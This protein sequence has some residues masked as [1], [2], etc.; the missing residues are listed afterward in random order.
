MSRRPVGSGRQATQSARPRRPQP[1]QPMGKSA[2]SARVTNIPS[3]RDGA[4]R[5]LGREARAWKRHRDRSTAD[6]QPRECRGR[7]DAC[8]RRLR[9]RT[10]EAGTTV[11]AEG[12]FGYS[13]CAYGRVRLIATRPTGRRGRC[14]RAICRGDDRT[15]RLERTRRGTR[16]ARRIADGHRYDSR[17]RYRGTYDARITGAACD[18]S[19]RDAKVR[20]LRHPCGCSNA[21]R[22]VVRFMRGDRFGATRK[23]GR[24]YGRRDERSDRDRPCE[25]EITGD[26]QG[27]AGRTGACD[28]QAI[29]QTRRKRVARRLLGHAQ[30]STRNRSIRTAGRVATR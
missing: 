3:Y 28:A 5:P 9:L 26:E 1:T 4:G 22:D 16:S 27:D 8:V 15:S 14:E 10:D 21:R 24:R 18:A 7:V 2:S 25:R 20:D 19:V 13:E 17:V 12:R 29:D 6:A 23:D 30:C 11:V